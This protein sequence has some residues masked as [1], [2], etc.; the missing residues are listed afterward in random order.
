MADPG[1]AEK[2]KDWIDVLDLAEI[3]VSSQDDL[4]PIEDALVQGPTLGWRASTPGPQEL[5][6]IF[7]HPQTIRQIMFHVIERAAQRTQEVVISAGPTADALQEV[8]RLRFA[9]DPAGSTEEFEDVPMTISDVGVLTIAI[10]P[11]L[12][13]D[14]AHTVN[15]ASLASL[16]IR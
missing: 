13:R 12:G 4:F 9:F 1:T 10:D 16:K 8:T 7:Q 2:A 15:Y 6:L 3:E 14:A 5:R 11:D